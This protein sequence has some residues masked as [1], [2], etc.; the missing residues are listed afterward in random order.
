MKH[1]TIY[2]GFMTFCDG[3]YDIEPMGSVNSFSMGLTKLNYNSEK[4]ELDVYVRRPGLLIG[5]SGEN[6]NKL[7]NYLGCSIKI[8]EV[9]KLWD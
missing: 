6:I 7:E 4:N 5:R 9:I 1:T 3:C 8:I 2:N